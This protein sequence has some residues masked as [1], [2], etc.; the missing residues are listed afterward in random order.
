MHRL[1]LAEVVGEHRA[2][3]LRLQVGGDEL[4]E[5]GAVHVVG[6]QHEQRVGVGLADLVA[7]AAQQVGVALREAAALLAAPLFGAEHEQAAAGAVQVPRA[8]ARDRA[9][10]VARV[11]LHA[12]EHVGDVAVHEVAQRDVDEPVRAAE[13]Q[14]GLGP[15]AGERV[16][17]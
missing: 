12:D 7:H 3:G 13:G 8:P 17:S 9:F 11:V 16:E 4:A 14:H 5:V 15:F 1:R 6:R 10:D 2:R